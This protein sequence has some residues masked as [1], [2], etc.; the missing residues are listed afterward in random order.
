MLLYS[1]NWSKRRTRLS[2]THPSRPMEGPSVP[3]R[4]SGGKGTRGGLHSDGEETT[5][6]LINDQNNNT[7]NMY[8]FEGENKEV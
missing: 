3:S 2:S 6:R 8:C 5:T 7:W 1:Y 4:C